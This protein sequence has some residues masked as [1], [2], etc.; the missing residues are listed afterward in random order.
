MGQERERDLDSI[1]GGHV[2]RGLDSL[3]EGNLLRSL[4]RGKHPSHFP[5]SIR[6]V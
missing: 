6:I 2:L 4:Y 1:G 5:L 3:G